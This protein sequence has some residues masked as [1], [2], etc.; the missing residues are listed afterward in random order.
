MQQPCL[1]C[2]PIAT[3]LPKH[4]VCQWQ[5]MKPISVP[6][7]RI[8]MNPPPPLGY[9]AYPAIIVLSTK[10]ACGLIPRW[11]KRFALRLVGWESVPASCSMWPG[12]RS[13]PKPAAAMMWCLAPCYWAACKAARGLTA[14]WACLSTPCLCVFLW[15]GARYTPSY[16]KPTT[17]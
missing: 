16:R 7:W 12:P 10:I 1:P 17:I 15:A 2:C 11:Q 13:W 9:S 3:L 14:Y 8:L 5:S 6:N 4:S